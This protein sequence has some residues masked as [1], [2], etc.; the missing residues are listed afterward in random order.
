MPTH[1]SSS[2]LNHT[3]IYII[4]SYALR[5]HFK[6]A[7]ASVL[8]YCQQLKVRKCTPLVHWSLGAAVSKSRAI[9]WSISLIMDILP[10]CQ[11][12][13]TCS[14]ISSYISSHA[15]NNIYDPVQWLKIHINSLRLQINTMPLSCVLFTSDTTSLSRDHS[16]DIRGRLQV[17]SLSRWDQ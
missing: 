12:K 14:H 1:I 4:S 9:T 11:C 5:S 13:Q 17:I 2:K 16:K 7:N 6:C 8:I 10:C 3:D 15:N